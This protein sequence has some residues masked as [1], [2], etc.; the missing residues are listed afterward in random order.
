MLLLL[1]FCIQNAYSQEKDSLQNYSY[2]ELDS[3]FLKNIQQDATK[4]E[5]YA[6]I[7]FRKAKSESNLKRE[8]ESLFKLAFTKARNKNFDS[9]HNYIDKA[10]DLADK[11]LNDIAL[12]HKY[13]LCKGDIYIN[14]TDYNNAFHYY[15]I[16]YNFEK[17]RNNISRSM[18]IAHNI[19]IIKT[20]IG[21]APEGIKIFK[22]NYALFV[23]QE[24]EQIDNF[25]SGLYVITLTALSD[26]YVDLAIKEKVLS[27]KNSLLDSA[28]YFNKI[29]F[30]KSTQYNNQDGYNYFLIRKAIIASEKGNYKSAIDDLNLALQKAGELKQISTL[31]TIYFHLAKNFKKIEELDKSILYFQKVDSMSSKNAK[32]SP[33][34]PETYSS[35]TQIYIQQKEAELALKYYNLFLEIDKLNDKQTIEIRKKVHEEYDIELLNNEIKQLT[36]TSKTQASKYT[37]AVSVLVIITIVFFL[38]FIDNRTKQKKNRL[39]FNKLIQELEAKKKETSEGKIE[40]ITSDTKS[41]ASP[42]ASLTIDEEKVQKIL[43]ELNK[44]EQKKQFLDINCNLTF[45]AKKVKTNKAYLSKVIHTEKQQK[46]IQYITNLRIDYALEK[47]KDDKLFRSYDIKSI[48]TELGFKSP[49]SFS[50]AFKN[51]TGIYPSYYIKNINKIN[52]SEEK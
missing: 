40:V 50:R 41:N 18:A 26:T 27:L 37:I 9:A 16:A 38:F 3:L 1:L 14:A 21:Q 22:D 29:G 39:A 32:N 17:S 25:D 35:L 10:V 2:K 15:K 4:A 46:F 8:G 23:S 49:D 47:L 52:T 33:L 31:S 34:L 24:Q 13:L 11:K 30:K 42:R 51:K 12:K 43:T 45:V 20:D 28:T 44:F 48:A 6:K 19:G 7:L 5:Q 36:T